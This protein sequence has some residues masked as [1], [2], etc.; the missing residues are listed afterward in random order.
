KF[1]RGEITAIV[2]HFALRTTPLGR[3]TYGFSSEN[4]FASGLKVTTAE[5][6]GMMQYLCWDV[7]RFW[8]R[9]GTGTPSLASG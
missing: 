4:V 8:N 2:K 7:Y 3:I 5:K 9:F 1:E 6:R